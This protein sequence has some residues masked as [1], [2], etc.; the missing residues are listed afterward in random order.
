MDLF[1]PTCL[2]YKCSKGCLDVPIDVLMRN[3][4]K[5]RHFASK[6]LKLWRIN[7]ADQF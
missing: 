5:V 6:Q 3:D 1:A 2:D 7:F 4:E